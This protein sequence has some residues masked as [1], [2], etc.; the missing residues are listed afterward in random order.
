MNHQPKGSMCATCRYKHKNCK[1][2][3]F[4]SMPPHQ[5]QGD[6]IVVICSKFRHERDG[7]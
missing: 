3:D 1:G 7:K 5:K 4:A 6:T 2:L